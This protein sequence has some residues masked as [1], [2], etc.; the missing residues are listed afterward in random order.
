[1]GKLAAALL[2]ILAAHVLSP[3]AIEACGGTLTRVGLS[4]RFV[5][6]AAKKNPA[7]VGLYAPR[8]GAFA[9]FAPRLQSYL[10]EEGHKVRT[11]TTEAALIEALKLGQIDAIVT[12]FPDAL[13]IQSA[14]SSHAPVV[15]IAYKLS[16]ADKAKA[17][18][19]K[20]RVEDPND[21]N[22]YMLA[23][24]NIMKVKDKKLT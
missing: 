14:A 22:E 3:T 20:H 8:S 23:L 10:T 9:T 12:D 13:A 1:M 16:K 17:K 19:Y 15:P 2:L 11:I 5:R 6:D 4:P 24:Y 7:K 21:G 18:T